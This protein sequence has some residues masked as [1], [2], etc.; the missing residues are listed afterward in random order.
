M[1]ATLPLTGFVRLPVVLQH[2][3]VGRSTWWAGVQGGRFPAPVKIG[4]VTAWRVQ[5]LHDLI[6]RLGQAPTGQGGERVVEKASAL[7]DAEDRR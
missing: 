3:P 2:I 7:R 5:D 4:G 1:K 6:E